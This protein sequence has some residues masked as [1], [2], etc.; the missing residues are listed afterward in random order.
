M[1]KIFVAFSHT[2]TDSQ[3]AGVGGKIVTLQEVA[4]E[5]HVTIGKIPA[6]ATLG[7]VKKLAQLVVIQAIESGASHFYIAGQPTLVMWANL[8]A[9]ARV[10]LFYDNAAKT[11]PEAFGTLSE[12]QADHNWLPFIGDPAIIVR[13]AAIPMV[14]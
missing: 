2:P 13:A 6:M 14:C 10:L 9:S 3:I 8:Y 1:E 5:L 4:P 11:W 12:I 7:Q